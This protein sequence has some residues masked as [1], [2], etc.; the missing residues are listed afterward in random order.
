MTRPLEAALDEMASARRELLSELRASPRGIEWCHA[1][2]DC[3]DRAVRAIAEIACGATPDFAIVATGGYGRRELA[4]HSD[5]DL[6]VTPVGASEPD[7]APLFRLLHDAMRRALKLEVGYAYLP[8]SDLRA[9]DQRT[10]TGLMDARLVWGSNVAFERLQSNLRN[11]FPNG[12]FLLQK[13]D[14]RS[15]AERKYHS[16]ALVT[17]PH[18]KEGRGG[19]R[20]LSASNWIFRVLGRQPLEPGPVAPRLFLVRNLLHMLSGRLNDALTVHRRAEIADLLSEDPLELGSELAREML[21][22][23][24]IYETA[25][26]AIHESRFVVA[27]GIEAI[28]GEARVT[29]AEDP[30]IAATGLAAAAKLGLRIDPFEWPDQRTTGGAAYDALTRDAESLRALD[31][32][33]LLKVLLPE[34]ERTRT[35]M[36]SDSVHKYTVFQHS[37][38]VFQLL[39]AP[40]SDPMLQELM[41]ALR[42]P[43][44]LL[45]AALLHDVGKG[46]D[47]RPHSEVG[48]EFARNVTSRFALGAE[49]ANIVHFLVRE[50]LAM[51]RCIRLRDLDQ[52][53]TVEEFTALVGTRERLDMLTLLTWADVNAVNEHAWT[54]AQHALLRKL[55]R[56][57]SAAIDDPNKLPEIATAAV[58]RARRRLESED[59]DETQVADFI[60]LMPGNYFFGAD[61]GGLLRDFRLFRDRPSSGSAVEF[62]QLPR[63]GVGEFAICCPD[64]PGLLADV[65]AVIYAFDLALVSAAVTTTISDP[66][67]ALD[68][69]RATYAGRAVPA[70]SGARVAAV[71]KD[72][73]DGTISSDQVLRAQGKDPLRTQR[74]FQYTFRPGL[75]ALLEVRAPRG[76]GLAFR[77]VRQLSQSGFDISAARFGQWAGQAA[78][79]FYLRR[80]SG[81]GVSL[82]EIQTVLQSNS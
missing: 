51:A 63:E 36:P 62:V 70:A 21:H 75:P 29:K 69:V 32:A 12:E 78:A 20:C 1:H 67:T 5:V 26:R 47:D 56:L 40:K 76:R 41:D 52:I 35:L 53:E 81:E 64:R 72:V 9:V 4:P 55:H 3:V 37:I 24:R 58:G 48:E 2:T 28:N 43:K 6:L 45:L 65:F 14:E 23:A 25:V 46:L 31:K 38:L 60:A 79:S 80:S 44:P 10:R 50:H 57:A 59:I 8:N 15:L 82:S 16:T 22:V 66:P 17:E 54:D 27:P 49:T 73:L 77:I 61:E 71:L 7:L 18:L 42:D 74:E 68:H 13:L 34:L 11:S 30:G 39:E 33:G 19:L